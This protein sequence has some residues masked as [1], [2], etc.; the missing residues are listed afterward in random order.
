[1]LFSVTVLSSR[2][3]H[4]KKQSQEPLLDSLTI[5][6]LTFWAVN[7]NTDRL[8]YISNN[9]E[10]TLL[11]CCSQTWPIFDQTMSPFTP[12]LTLQKKSQP[13][14]LA[15]AYTQKEACERACTSIHFCW[16][17]CV[18]ICPCLWVTERRRDTVSL[19]SDCSLPW[20]TENVITFNNSVPRHK[21]WSNKAKLLHVCFNLCVL[22]QLLS[23]S[24][25]HS[26]LLLPTEL[27][28]Q[29]SWGLVV[30]NSVVV[31]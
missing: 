28:H 18:C 10:P 24:F 5:L 23:N 12:T 31:F 25:N 1:M 3:W 22:F 19:F 6:R 13:N 27:L 11:V 21:S 15:F 30:V 20:F 29:R 7:T 9:K 17:V 4:L 2:P 26:F 8:C 14:E 16:L